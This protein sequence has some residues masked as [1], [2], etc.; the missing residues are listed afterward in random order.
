MDGKALTFV[1]QVP[2]VFGQLSVIGITS[3]PEGF[4]VVVVTSFKITAY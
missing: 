1:L 4:G 2:D 3:V